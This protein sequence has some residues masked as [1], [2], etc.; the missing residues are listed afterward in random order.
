MEQQRSLKV[1][2]VA[3]TV[4]TV[5]FFLL[6]LVVQ[7]AWETP[8]SWADNNISDLGNVTCGSFGGR[9]LCSPLHD[10]MNISF[11]LGG[12]LLIGGTLL[13]YS[14]W[15]RSAVSYLTR[16]LLI[17]TGAGWAVGWNASPP[18]EPRSGLR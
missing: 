1:G 5:Q 9:T 7:L 17:A 11:I 16:L 18:T 14:A 10:L 2:A 3:W 4:A 15:P 12:V 8:Y 6:M 13:T